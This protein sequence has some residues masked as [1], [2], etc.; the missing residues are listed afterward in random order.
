MAHLLA[1]ILGSALHDLILDNYITDNF[2][3]TINSRI[4]ALLH[5]RYSISTLGRK[6]VKIR[7]LL[8]IAHEVVPIAY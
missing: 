6:I 3:P 4:T 8:R 1:K 5:I 7:L 2:K